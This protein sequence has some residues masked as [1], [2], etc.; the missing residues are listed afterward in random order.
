MRFY[1]KLYVGE[2]VK[3]TERVKWKLRLKVGQSDIYLIV[4]SQNGDN[5]LEFFQSGLLKQKV[6]R[7]QDYFIVGIAGN[8]KEAVGLIERIT[9]DCVDATGTCNI[10]AF[11]LDESL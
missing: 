6:F 1:N 7:R 5:Q 8:Y 9:Q 3:H 11:L 10:K 4:V 2:S